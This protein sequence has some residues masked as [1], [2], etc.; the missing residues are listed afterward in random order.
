MTN[1]KKLERIKRKDKI[2]YYLDIA[3]VVS[4]QCTCLR[5]CYGAVIVKNDESIVGEFGY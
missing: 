3:D 2:N 4:N 5:R 1:N